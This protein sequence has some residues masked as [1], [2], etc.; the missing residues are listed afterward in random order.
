MDQQTGELIE[1]IKKKVADAESVG[2]MEALTRIF[3]I[4]RL[5]VKYENER[6]AQSIVVE[7]KDG[8]VEFPLD[9]KSAD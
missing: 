7:T 2:P 1:R 5:L 4:K 8:L 9:D 6:P 3:E